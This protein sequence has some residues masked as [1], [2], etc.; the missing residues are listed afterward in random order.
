MLKTNLTWVLM[1]I[2][3]AS[4]EGTPPHFCVQGKEPQARVSGE[5]AI[6]VLH[7]V[8]EVVANGDL[9]AALAQ[10][11]SSSSWEQG[12]EGHAEVAFCG[13]L[14]DGSSSNSGPHESV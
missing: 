8:S 9:V 4:L 11:V 5:A 10:E 7:E 12:G 1:Y 6:I 3:P 14:I 2:D 13:K